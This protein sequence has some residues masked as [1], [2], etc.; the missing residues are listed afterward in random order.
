MAFKKTELNDYCQM[1][2]IPMEGYDTRQTRNGFVSSLRCG[3]ILFRSSGSHPTKKSAENDVASVA[4]RELRSRDP[5]DPKSGQVSEAI[6][7]TEDFAA[8]ANQNFGPTPAQYFPPSPNKNFGAMPQIPSPVKA[9][10]P[11]TAVPTGLKSD[12]ERV[13]QL[14][15]RYCHLNQIPIWHKVS[16]N[17]SNRHNA[18]VRIGDKEYA[19]PNEH[20]S[21]DEAKHSV[22]MLAMKELRVEEFLRQAA[23]G[24]MPP[25]MPALHYI[26]QPLPT[27]NTHL[28]NNPGPVPY[29]T[30]PVLAPTS[31]GSH[32]VVG[33]TAHH[34]YKD[35]SPPVN[36]SS[37]GLLISRGGNDGTFV[38]NQRVQLDGSMDTPVSDN[39]IVSVSWNQGVLLTPDAFIQAANTSKPVLSN[40]QQSIASKPNASTITPTVNVTSKPISSIPSTHSSVVPPGSTAP[41]PLPPVTLPSP[42]SLL[43]IPTFPASLPLP[44][45][46]NAKKKRN[47]AESPTEQFKPPLNS[48]SPSLMAS[49]S[50]PQASNNQ[51][52]TSLNIVPSHSFPVSVPSHSPSVPTEETG[53]GGTVEMYYKQVLNDYVQKQRLP[54]P[55][56]TTEYP[57]NSLGYIGIVTL[58]GVEYRSPPD[59][60]KKRALNLAAREALVSHGVIRDAEPSLPSV[61]SNVSYKNILQEYYQKNKYPMPQ[62]ST[63]GVGNGKFVCSLTCTVSHGSR[64]V[65]FKGIECTTKKLAEQSAAETACIALGLKSS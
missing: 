5:V 62:Y 54:L 41:P 37:E 3:N 11:C 7:K 63:V 55:L 17:G 10:V 59:K 28:P 52:V 42:T 14:L 4:L 12:Y 33:A 64:Q 57:E 32:P 65:T 61:Q 16:N 43:T 45:R 2:K 60:N 27:N 47:N 15:I 31:V 38:H 18:M 48:S 25:V 20:P 46:N 19:D 49:S 23:A 51:G 56:F 9:T 29:Y 39:S 44:T 40:H 13:N 50:I 21:F 24:Q 1:N 53:G 30:Q 36:S 58:D 8:K 35:N 26:Q 6:D 34:Q 22:N